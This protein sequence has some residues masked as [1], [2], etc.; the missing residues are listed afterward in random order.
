M[1]GIIGYIGD[2]QAQ[3]ILLN[4]LRHLEYRGY[5]SAGMCTLLENKKTLSVRKLPGKV[6]ELDALLK[7]KPLSGKRGLSHCR[8]ATHG[9][10]NQVNAHPHFDCDEEIVLV[11]N[12][13]I[14]NYAQLKESLIKEGHVFKSK[15]DTE[16]IVHLIEKYYKDSI[17][18]EDA[19]RK[20]LSKLEGAYAIGVLS[21]RE[22]DKLV[23]AR[24]GSPLVVGIGKK[25]NFL[26]SDIPAL[27]DYTKDVL[28]LEDNELVVLTQDGVQ[29]SDIKGDMVQRKAVTISWDVSQAQKQGWPHFMLKEINEQPAVLEAMQATRYGEAAVV[30]GRVQAAPAGRVLLRTAIGS[31]RVVDM[32][33]GEML[34]RIC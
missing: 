31:T 10:P 8:W 24:N 20:A 13:I 3:P 15:T 32:L 6:K 18:L 26:A 1:C 34:P 27:L 2:K 29:I 9:A 21:S 17:M 16:V 12:G 5:D 25:E 33:A 19:V 11:H 22:P 28:F 30:I 23:G 7:H 4:G 14:E